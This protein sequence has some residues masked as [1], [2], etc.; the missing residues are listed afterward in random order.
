MFPI[1]FL[2][3]IVLLSTLQLVSIPLSVVHQ[4]VKNIKITNCKTETPPV[5]ADQNNCYSHH[6]IC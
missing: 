6:Y 2:H 1:L 4:T 5:Q 3:F